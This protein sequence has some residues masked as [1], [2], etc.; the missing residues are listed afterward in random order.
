MI[1]TGVRLQ[2]LDILICTW[3]YYQTCVNWVIDFCSFITYVRLMKE[4]LYTCATPH[5]L[6]GRFGSNCHW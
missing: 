2:H 3:S 1:S 4:I 5:V 6:Y